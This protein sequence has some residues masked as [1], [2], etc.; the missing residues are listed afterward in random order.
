MGKWKMGMGQGKEVRDVCTI[1]SNS[2]VYPCPSFKTES[3]LTAT[4]MREVFYAV[5]SEKDAILDS[6]ALI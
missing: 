4:V 6:V 2:C 3:K 1:Q 5:L